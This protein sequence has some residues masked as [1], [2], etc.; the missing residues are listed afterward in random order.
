MGCLLPTKLTIGLEVVC[1]LAD[2]PHR[3]RGVGGGGVEENSVI[4]GS[5]QIVE[6]CEPAHARWSALCGG[7]LGTDSSDGNVCS[8][9]M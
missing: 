4:D 8:E 3:P 2:Q 7:T 1:L 5:F 9:F 6:E